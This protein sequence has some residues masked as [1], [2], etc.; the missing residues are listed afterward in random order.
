MDLE[1]KVMK[2]KKAMVEAKFTVLG[3]INSRIRNLIPKYYDEEETRR[4]NED[5]IKGR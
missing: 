5:K 1:N 2:I 4:N 3:D